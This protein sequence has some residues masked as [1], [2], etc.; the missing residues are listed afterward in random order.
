MVVGNNSMLFVCEMH[1]E[2]KPGHVGS[3]FA[4]ARQPLQF[5]LAMH[6]FALCPFHLAGAH[7]VPRIVPEWWRWFHRFVCAFSRPCI[8]VVFTFFALCLV[9]FFSSLFV[10]VCVAVVIRQTDTIPETICF[11]FLWSHHID[12]H[13]LP[14]ATGS[15][16][17]FFPS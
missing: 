9:S 2:W 1:G 15:L 6:I 13:V 5:L 16:C 8:S 10:C 7:L 12:V 14:V 17:R 4:K 3:R 11:W